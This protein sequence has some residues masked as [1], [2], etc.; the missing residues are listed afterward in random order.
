MDDYTLLSIIGVGHNGCNAVNSLYGKVIHTSLAICDAYEESLSGSP[1]KNKVL[2][3]QGD[4]A[5]SQQDLLKL[6]HPK[7]WI[8]IILAHLDNHISIQVACLLAK[9][10]KEKA[11]LT[12]VIASMPSPLE[13]AEKMAMAHKGYEELKGNVDSIFT[14]DSPEDAT[15]VEDYFATIEKTLG[16]YALCLAEINT[17]DNLLCFDWNNFRTIMEDCGEAI[18]AVSYGEGTHRLRIAKDEAIAHIRKRGYDP[19]QAKWMLVMLIYR[20][21]E[22]D[23][24]KADME[25][26]NDFM[27]KFDDKAEIKWGIIEDKTLSKE[28]NFEIIVT[29]KQ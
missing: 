6:L 3:K 27:M 8:K 15:T 21:R 17:T 1:V 19:Y 18:L 25:D 28:M 13:G 7:A 24:M 9:A 20:K 2:L 10:A 26:L 16:E 29:E 4:M 11:K 5:I 14:I 12:I 23:N 22:D